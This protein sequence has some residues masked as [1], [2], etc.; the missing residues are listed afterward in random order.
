MGRIRIVTDS[1]ARY[2]QPEL[3]TRYP[4]TIVPMHVDVGGRLVEDTPGQEPWE[5]LPVGDGA[6]GLPRLV[7]P[8]VDTMTT[9]Y[10][11]LLRETDQILSIHSTARV[12]AAVT[13]AT[14]A[15]QNFRGRCEIQVVDSQSLSVGQ[16][17]LIEAAAAGL[18]SRPRQPTPLRSCH[19]AP[20]TMHS[21]ARPG[22]LYLSVALK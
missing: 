8:S 19:A 10:A 5:V 13:N 7:A 1:V 20:V 16:G 17:L 15:S 22:P 4:V 2:A 9:V 11:Q 12:S 18:Q 6:L 3:L 14:L 21:D